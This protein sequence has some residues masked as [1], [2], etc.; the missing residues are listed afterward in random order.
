MP[1]L[2]IECSVNLEGGIQGE[3]NIWFVALFCEDYYSDDILQ[4]GVSRIHS[5]WVSHV[6]LQMYGIFSSALWVCA[7]LYDAG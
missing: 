6:F 4:G 1:E 2:Q 7:R 5:Y 3:I